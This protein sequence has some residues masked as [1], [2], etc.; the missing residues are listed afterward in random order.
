MA[1]SLRKELPYDASPDA[2]AGMLADPSFREEVLQRQRVLRGSAKVEGRVV[3]VEQVQSAADL[4]SFARSI[5]GDEIVIVQ[6]ERWA[7]DT[8]A[9]VHLAIPGKPGDITGTIRLS[10]TSTGTLEVVDLTVKVSIP[11]VAGKIE[12]LVAQMIEKALTK[13]YEVG[14]EW[15]AR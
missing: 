2:V 7:D 3:T 10:P 4:P 14:R 8:A 1:T 6:T 11:L 9:D 13:E 12:K 5:V 15:L